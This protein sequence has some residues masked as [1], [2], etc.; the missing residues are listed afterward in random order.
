[1]VGQIAKK[2]ATLVLE[3]NNET[4]KDLG[5]EGPLLLQMK[6]SETVSPTDLVQVTLYEIARTGSDI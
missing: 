6:V 4:N 2:Y 5:N 3:L 1:M